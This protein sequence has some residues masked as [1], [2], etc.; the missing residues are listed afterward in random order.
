MR[1]NRFYDR[2]SRRYDGAF[3]NDYARNDRG[4]SPDEGITAAGYPASQNATGGDVDVVLYIVV[5]IKYG[6]GV[7]NGESRDSCAGVYDSPRHDHSSRTDCD[8]RRNNGC[9]VDE[10]CEFAAGCQDHLGKL[11]P[12]RGCTNRNNIAVCCDV[13]WNL[14][15]NWAAKEDVS[16]DSCR[17]VIENAIGRLIQCSGDVCDDPAVTAIAD[18]DQRSFCRRHLA[19]LP[20]S[21]V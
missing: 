10:T 7:D 9:W 12:N 20:G 6:S 15:A 18:D 19:S 1:R 5:V 11:P 14:A 2:R 17:F 21:G 13:A 8:I 16:T 3:A 4:A